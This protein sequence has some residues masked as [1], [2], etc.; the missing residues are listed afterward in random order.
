MSILLS[1][2]H[3]NNGYSISKNTIN[4][5][6]HYISY[7]YRYYSYSY[8]RLKEKVNKVKEQYE[9]MEPLDHV[10]LRPGMYVGQMEASSVETWYNYII[11]IIYYYY[12]LL[13]IL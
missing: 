4:L 11:Y 3:K 2:L 10:L 9:R 6:N 12:N 13:Y 1:L 5:C 7:R 8:N